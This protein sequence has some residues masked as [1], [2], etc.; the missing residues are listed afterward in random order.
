[1]GG[2]GWFYVPKVRIPP[3]LRGD[4]MCGS[5]LSSC[6]WAWR[7]LIVDGTSARSAKPHEKEQLGL[8]P[9]LVSVVVCAA[10]NLSMDT[11]I[12]AGIEVLA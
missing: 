11:K 6:V 5:P 8:V 7:S 9:E 12:G 2:G 3:A 1:M 10:Q 4:V